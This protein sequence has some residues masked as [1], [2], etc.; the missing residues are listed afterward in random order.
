MIA[1]NEQHLRDGFAR[2]IQRGCV[3]ADFLTGSSRCDA[4]S[5][6][7]AADI[8]SAQPAIAAWRESGIV[9]K[10]RNINPGGQR[11]VHDGLPLCKRDFLSVDDNGVVDCLHRHLIQVRGSIITLGDLTGI[12]KRFIQIE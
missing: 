7:F 6:T 8:H 9:A 2:I 4:R 10:M 3:I 12:F 1:F 11:C 5:Y